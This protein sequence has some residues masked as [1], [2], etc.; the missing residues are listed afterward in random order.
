[1]PEVTDVQMGMVLV[2]LTQRVACEVE[3]TFCLS[4]YLHGVACFSFCPS[5]LYYLYLFLEMVMVFR[6]GTLPSGL[7]PAS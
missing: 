2:P 7:T 3:V 6:C 5:S 4:L 1:M